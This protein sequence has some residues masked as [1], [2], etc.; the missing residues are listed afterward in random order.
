M[1]HRVVKQ[2]LL[3]PD[4]Y[5]MTLEYP[6]PEKPVVPGQF[7]MVRV[8]RELDPLLRRPLSVHEI[9]TN[10]SPPLLKFLYQVV[11][12]GT[13]I[14]SRLCPGGEID[15]LGPL[16]NG[17]SLLPELE[18]AILIAGGMGVAPFSGLTRM[19]R[20]DH[21]ACRITAFIGGKTA[22][23]IYTVEDLSRLG[24]KVQAVTEDGSLGI[25]GL[26]TEAL[27]GHLS[28]TNTEKRQ[29]FACGPL[30]MMQRTAQLAERHGTP[31]Q[32]SLDKAMACGVGACRG[33]VVPVKDS[34]A[35]EEY[36]YK[37]VCRDGPVFDAKTL[38]FPHT[39]NANS[40]G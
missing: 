1:V 33:C 17:F 14:L 24:V 6:F 27:D 11:G 9:D 19:I 3:G 13:S 12:R 5:R 18:E 4:V 39:T 28:G 34:A 7:F 15:I 38:L 32:V 22:A 29:I 10:H 20:R 36:H 35:S 16:G 23:D 8:G 21:P 30:G 37:T 40:S 26:V 31:C 2:D 25:R